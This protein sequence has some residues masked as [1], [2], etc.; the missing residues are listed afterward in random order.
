MPALL[1]LQ[2]E[3]GFPFVDA[4]MNQLRTEGWVHHVGRHMIASYL[5]RGDLWLSWEAGVRVC[6]LISAIVYVINRTE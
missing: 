5:T 1:Y 3:T 4:I 6:L 2:G